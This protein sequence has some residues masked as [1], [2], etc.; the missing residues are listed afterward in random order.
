MAKK[1]R[2]TEIR[3]TISGFRAGGTIGG[4]ASVRESE[5]GGT[6]DEEVLIRPE[7]AELRRMYRWD[8]M[9]EEGTE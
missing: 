1:T 4:M 6:G 9:D 8:P 2:W 5:F 7:D 3:E